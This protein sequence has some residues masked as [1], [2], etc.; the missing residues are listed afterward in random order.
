MSRYHF[1]LHSAHAIDTSLTYELCC[2]QFSIGDTH[3]A[4]AKDAF[5]PDHTTHSLAEQANSCLQDAVRRD[6]KAFIPHLGGFIVALRDELDSPGGLIARNP[7]SVER[8]PYRMD[9]KPDGSGIERLVLLA[10]DDML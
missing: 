2:H 9:V 1:S 7:P 3:Q 6:G 10:V 8:R 4:R 5:L